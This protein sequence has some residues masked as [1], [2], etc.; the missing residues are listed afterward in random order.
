MRNQRKRCRTRGEEIEENSGREDNKIK[1]ESE[2]KGSGH[3]VISTRERE[4]I[5]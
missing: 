4:A 2:R 3:N 1:S 5:D